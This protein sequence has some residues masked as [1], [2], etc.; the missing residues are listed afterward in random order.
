MTKYVNDNGVS[1]MWANTKNYISAQLLGKSDVGHTHNVSDITNLSENNGNM[2]YDGH[3]VDTIEEQGNRYIRY[4]NGIQICWGLG[5]YNQG[6]VVSYAKAFSETPSVVASAMGNPINW[7]VAH[8]T[9][10][11]QSGSFNYVSWQAIGRW[12]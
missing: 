11:I 9:M 4:S 7:N 12:K 3:I 8:F 6:Q 5:E 1:E 10:D 2:T